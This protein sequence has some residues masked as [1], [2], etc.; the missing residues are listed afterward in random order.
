MH[1]TLLMLC[2]AFAA[3]TISPAVADDQWQPL[4]NGKDLTGWE[5]VD[6]PADA[7][8]A[9]DGLL[10][11]E[12]SGGG[13]LSTSKEFAN[14][15]LELEFKVPPGGNSG[16]FLRAPRQGNPAYAGMEIQVLDDYAKEYENLKPS[17]YTGSVYDVV[18]AEPRVTKKAGEW[19]T[20]RIV[21]DRHKVKVWVNDKQVVDAD[22][23]MHLDKIAAHPGLERNKGHI[24]LQ[25]H[26]S[27][28]DFRNLK[29]RELP[30]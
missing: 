9:E 5:A 14:F 28:L 15:D 24:G 6:G 11:C 25:N 17:Q 3:L 7:W 12:G 23:S 29:I 2:F 1:R 13:W 18:A 20:M 4:F 30:Q 22:L 26:G 8:R 19:Q 21:C 16:V 27:R 10:V